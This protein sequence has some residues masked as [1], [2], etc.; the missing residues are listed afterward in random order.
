VFLN[1]LEEQMK[2]TIFELGRLAIVCCLIAGSAFAQ[3]NQGRITGLVQD[4]SQGAIP[5]ASVTVTND[6]TGEMRT[7]TTNQDGTFLVTALP[8]ST[9]TIRVTKDQF[10]TGEATNVQVTVGQQIRREFTLRVASAATSVTVTSGEEAPIDTTSARIG[11]NVNEREVE[12]LP[13]NG[14]Q[15]SQLYL[16]APGSLNSGT[17]TFQ[18]IRFSGRAVEQNAIRYDG[19]E[20]SAIVDA[21]PGNLN[22]E[23]P[24]PF[25]LQ[26]SLENV[27]EFRVESNNYPAEYGTGTGGQISVITKS[28]SNAFHGSAFEYLRNDAMDAKNYFDL[29]QSKLRLNQ[30]GASFGGRLIRDKFFFYLYYEGYRLRSGIN[31]VEA[32]PS[33]AVRAL[34]VCTTGQTP[35][36]G[37]CVTSAT[38][39]LLAGFIGPGAVFLPGK[40]KDPNFDIYQLQDVVRVNENSGGLRL[41][42]H[43]NSSHSLSARYFRDQGFN[44]APEGVTGRRAAITAN[45]QNGMLALN[46]LF[47]ANVVNELKFGYNNAYTR[48]V[49][50]AP[51]ING[52]DY[53]KIVINTSGSVANAGIAGQGSS[54]GLAVPGGLVRANSATNGHAAP[55]TPYTLSFIDNI[56]WVSGKHSMKFGGEVRVLRFY[57]DRIGGT[58]YSFSD[59]NALVKNTPSQVQFLGDLSAPSVFNNGASGPIKGEQEYYILYGQDEVKLLPSLTL[60]YG[61][62]YEYY[63]PMRE[64]DNRVIYLDTNTGKLGCASPAPICDN[65]A[66]DFLYHANATNFGPRVGLAWSPS[67]SGNGLFGGGHTVIRGGVGMFYGPGQ[68]E[69][70]LQPLESDRISSTRSSGAVYPLDPATLSADFIKWT[71]NPTDP[72]NN[73]GFQPRAYSNQYVNPERIYQ[74]SV[75]WQQQWGQFVSTIA[76]VGSQGRNLFLR[77][78]TNRIISVDPATGTVTRQFDIVQGSTILRPYAEVDFKESGGHDSYNALQMSLVRR[79]TSGL[80]MSAQYTHSKSFGNSAGSNEAQTSGN[81]FDYEYDNGYNNFDVRDTFNIS[82]LYQLPIGRNQRFLRNLSG[83]AEHVLGNWQ[84]GTI[85]NARSGVPLNILITRPDIVWRGVAGATTSSGASLAGQVFGSKVTTATLTGAV[86]PGTS[87]IPVGQCTEAIINVPG[88]GASRNVRRPDL[89]PGVDPFLSNGYVNPAAFATPAPGT[90]GNLERGSVHGPAFAQADLTVSKK[91]VTSETTSVNFRVEIFNILNHPNFSNPPVTLGNVLGIDTTKNQLQPGQPF[92]A[93]SAGPF[94]KFNQTVGTTVGLG[95]NRQIQFALRFDF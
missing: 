45:P 56:S 60:N 87:V 41:D 6:R 28:G 84:L 67:P 54:S 92:S 26:S 75:S 14:R 91:F 19:V 49:G 7:T 80:T 5:G 94:G 88:G 40:S 47:G 51:T 83:I 43:I 21:A 86:C 50:D 11:I 29:T 78:W 2:K 39:P 52:V 95:T 93:S 59:L 37:S 22:G 1:A 35:G 71:Q 64:K 32:V 79:L 25:R 81:P 85:I 36:I 4:E 31:A 20:G 74:Y 90:F 46:S 18:D 15:L 34:P 55:Y 10:T 8:P 13:I 89:V 44:S 72:T 48:I 70:T 63:S 33:A 3:V 17:G 30:F 65:P 58:T 68:L 23:V 73:R 24:S 38:Q 69:D 61:L 57:T 53:S 9:Y 77:N 16:Q 66:P 42:Y 12:G 82:A 62:R 27:Q 76:Y